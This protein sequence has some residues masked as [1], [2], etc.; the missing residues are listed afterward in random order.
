MSTALTVWDTDTI[1]NINVMKGFLDSSNVKSTTPHKSIL[2]SLDEKQE[3]HRLFIFIFVM[4]TIITSRM[5]FLQFMFKLNS[6]EILILLKY[7]TC[8]IL[9][10]NC[11]YSYSL[12]IYNANIMVYIFLNNVVLNKKAYKT[13]GG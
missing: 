12:S 2:L 9:Q 3:T 8:I 5:I 4:V 1:W 10:K 6:G 13:S 11:F 7:I